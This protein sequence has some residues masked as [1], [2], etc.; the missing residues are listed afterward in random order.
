[1]SDYVIIVW[2]TGSIDEA[3]RISRYLVQ[4]RLVA[5]ASIIPWVESIFLWNN[6][7]DTEQE[8]KVLLKTRR[9]RFDAVKQ[10]ILDNCAY[11]VPEITCLS[12]EDGNQAYFD[13]IDQSVGDPSEK[14]S[15]H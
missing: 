1:M 15:A 8:S 9:E 3:R 12:L 13:W 10:T 4:E 5:C 7:L 11:E 2:T 6:K 14:S